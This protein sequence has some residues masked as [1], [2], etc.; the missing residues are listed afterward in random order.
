[1][2]STSLLMLLLAA[3]HCGHCVELIQIGSTVLTPGQSLTLTCKVSGYSVTSTYCTNWIR[4]WS[5]SELYVMMVALPTV[6]N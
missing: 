5:G 4:L 1:M 3:V 2:I 6:R